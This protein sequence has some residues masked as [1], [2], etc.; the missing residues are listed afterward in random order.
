VKSF[1]IFYSESVKV[2]GS[3]GVKKL[4]ELYLMNTG[5]ALLLCG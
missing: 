1:I 4:A 3:D 2:K 5:V